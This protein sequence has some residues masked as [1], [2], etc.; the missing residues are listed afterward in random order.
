ML[1]PDQKLNRLKLSRALLAFRLKFQSDPANFLQ[2]ILTQNETWVHQFDPESKIIHVQTKRASNGIMPKKF[3]R[4]SSVGKLMASVFRDCEE[5]LMI[6]FLQKGQTI[7][8]EY[9][10]SNLRQLK[11]PIKSKRRGKLCAGVLLLQDNGPVLTAQVAVAEAE[12][13]G[14]A[15]SDFCLFPDLKSHLQGRR[16]DSDNDVICA[17]EG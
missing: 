11:E 16:F 3:K 2:R 4:V 7:N 8:G 14:L 6:D 12:R 1:T 17:V 10:A 15:P 9:H 13:C 5:V